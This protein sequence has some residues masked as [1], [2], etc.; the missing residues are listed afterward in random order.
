[1]LLA[2]LFLVV[3]GEG[4]ISLILVLG[5]GQW[6]TRKN[7]QSASYFTKR[8]EYVEAAKALGV[9]NFSIMFGSILPNIFAPLIACLF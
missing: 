4:L 5:V 6:V 1:M 9:N 2:I 8:K 3:L 7:S